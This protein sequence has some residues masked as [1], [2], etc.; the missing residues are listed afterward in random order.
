LAAVGRN[1]GCARDSLWDASRNVSRQDQIAG[2]FTRGSRIIKED[3]NLVLWEL[4]GGERYWVPKGSQKLAEMRAEQKRRIYGYGKDGV[5]KGDIVLDCGA[6]VGL[7]S[8]TAFTDGAARVI[9]IEPAPHNLECLRRNMAT[10][11]ASGRVVIYPKGVWDKDD[12]L[13]LRVQSTNSGAD[14]VALVYGDTHEGP[15]VLLTTIDKLVAELALT[16]VDF[17]K[18]DIEGAERAALTGAKNTLREF[19]PRMAI[20][21]EHQLNDP[22]ELPRLIRSIAPDYR[23]KCGPCVETGAS[24][25]PETLFFF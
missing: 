9:A 11:I 23:V 24:L 17:I 2:E 18:M 15:K 8:A 10:E 21:M 22:V 14:S 5:H 13:T 20:A 1:R 19:H 16:R 3:R 6:N 4:A 25:R 12:V 7:F